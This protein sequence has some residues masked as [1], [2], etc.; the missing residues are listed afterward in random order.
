MGQGQS[1]SPAGIV[2]GLKNAVTAVM[3]AGSPIIMKTP[4]SSARDTV[5][6]AVTAPS[7]L[8]GGSYV[9]DGGVAD[10]LKVCAFQTPQRVL[11]RWGKGTRGIYCINRGCGSTTWWGKGVRR[12]FEGVLEE[13]QGAACNMRVRAMAIGCA[14][15]GR[16]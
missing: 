14:I 15:G 12:V 9:A 7:A 11:R 1:L 10:G 8:V 2:S 5:M 13:V 3:N 4:L 6:W 16:G